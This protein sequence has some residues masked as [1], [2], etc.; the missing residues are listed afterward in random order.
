MKFILVF[1]LF[2]FSNL[3]Y[4][5]NGMKTIESQHNAADTANKLV[6]V[7]ENKGLKLFARINHSQN[8]ASLNMELRATEL[9]I[10]GNPK[11]GTPLMQCAQTTGL[12][13]PQKILIWEDDGGKTYIT[14][15]SPEYLKKRHGVVGC[16]K[17]LEKVTKA[18]KGLTH[19]AAN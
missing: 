14:Y 17:I 13:L 9:V 10:F 15:N 5:E 16:N 3:L 8:A 11:I 1:F 2:L 12:D 18:L 19:A 4:A 6:S 7:I